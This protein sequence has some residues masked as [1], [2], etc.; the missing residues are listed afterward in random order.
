MRT[1]YLDNSSTTPVCEAAADAARDAMLLHY[2]NPSSL[3][4]LGVEAEAIVDQA[5]QTIAGLLGAQKREILFT[6]CGTEAN[7]LALM[8][9]ASTMRRRGNRVVLSCVEH[10]SV[11]RSADALAERGYEVVRLPVG[12]DGVVPEDKLADA[13]TKETILVSL[14]LANNETG[15]IQP[16]TK[17][18]ECIRRSGAPA[19]L[20]CDAVQAFGKLP[21]RANDLKADLITLSGHKIHAPKGVGALYI[22]RGVRIL[23]QMLGGGQEGGL[24][25]GTESVPLIAAFGAAAEQLGDIPAHLARI[26]CLRK[27]CVDRLMADPILGPQTVLHST[28]D[29]LPYILNISLPGIRSETMLHFLEQRGVYV[30]AGSACAKGKKSAVLT[31]LG[32]P[33][34]EI[35]SALRISFS[36]FSTD[37]DVDQLLQALRDGAATLARTR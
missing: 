15:A 22:R 23:P 9:A 29:S 37:E 27:Q 7:N 12:P 25:S 3:H 21:F 32:L 14:M 35:D 4:A 13:I 36:R 19:L 16:V 11:A 20:H 6:S 18:A 8:G 5:R 17:A 31:A 26:R 24:R 28:D 10:P 30:S 1:A 2:G 33:D 34:R